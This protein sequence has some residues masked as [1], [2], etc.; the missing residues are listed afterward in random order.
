MGAG[1]AVADPP[2][3][4]DAKRQEKEGKQAPPVDPDPDPSGAA[5]E[6]PPADPQAK[7]HRGDLEGESEDENPQEE[8]EPD[9]AV[10]GS[11]KQL[12]LNVGGETPDVSVV[13]IR[14]K[15][16]TVKKGQ[17][18]KGEIVEFVIRAKCTG[19]SVDDKENDGEVTETVRRHTFKPI[20]VEKLPAGK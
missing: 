5:G 3:E 9:L 10:E 19:V 6:D 12:T 15:S 16:I 14:S 20:A 4:L 1:S 13:K 8:P 18:S 2:S 7:Q 17:Y 11:G